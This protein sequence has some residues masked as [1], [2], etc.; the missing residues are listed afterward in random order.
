MRLFAL[1][2]SRFC[3]TSFQLRSDLSL[4]FPLLDRSHALYFM[5]CSHIAWLSLEVHPLSLGCA[6]LCPRITIIMC[7]VTQCLP[8]IAAFPALVLSILS[9]RIMSGS[10]TPR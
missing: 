10:L 4:L 9:R 2:L 6:S 8:L 3:S 1:Q 5:V 7:A